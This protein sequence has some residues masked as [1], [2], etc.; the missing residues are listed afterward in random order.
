MLGKGTGNKGC[1]S[2]VGNKQAVILVDT[3]STGTIVENR[4]SGKLGKNEMFKNR[5]G[6]G[7]VVRQANGMVQDGDCR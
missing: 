6:Y 4:Y 3:G 7:N 5:V 2:R 1:D